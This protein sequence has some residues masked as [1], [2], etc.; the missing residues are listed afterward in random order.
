MKWTLAALLHMSSLGASAQTAARYDVL[1]SEILADTDPSAGL[2]NSSF[3]ELRNRSTHAI[4]LKGWTL[5]IGKNSLRITTDQKLGPDSLLILCSTAAA[6]AYRNYGSVLPI[7]GFP[8]LPDKGGTIA[9]YSND[10]RTIHAVDYSVGDYHN[11][12]KSEGG[13]SLEMIDASRPCLARDNWTASTDPGGGTPGK[14]N[15]VEGRVDDED[16]PHALRTF[17]PDS[18]HLLVLF[19]KTLD[20]ESASIPYRYH[21][22]GGPPVLAARPQPP[23][24]RSVM[25]DLS[26]PLTREKTCEVTVAGVEDCSGNL[27]SPQASLR[28]GLPAD[29]NPGG[30]VINEVLFNPMPD[31]TDYVELLNT[32]GSVLDAGSLYIGNRG[33]QGQL[34]S[35]AA[36]SPDP[37]LLFPGDHY[38]VSGDPAAVARSYLVKHPELLSTAISMPSMPDAEGTVVITDRQGRVLDELHYAESW[39]FALISDPEGVSLERIDPDGATQDAKNWHSAAADIGHGTPTWLN[40]QSRVADSIGTMWDIGPAVFS[41]DMDGWDDFLTLNYRFPDPGW[42]CSLTI[43]DMGGRPVRWLCRNELCGREGYFRW[44]GLDEGRRQPGY[45]AYIVVADCFNLQGRRQVYR[46]KVAIAGRPR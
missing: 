1:I 9:L 37:F 33:R 11:D 32:G 7:T 30:L 5:E 46:K 10:H 18:L 31:G 41:P 14:R 25:L 42:T 22:V 6:A 38:V 21:L 24:F 26:G 19:D 39:H 34:Q 20:S 45:G 17:P 23:F 12:L 2:P 13:W 36:C 43:Y 40:S 44:D 15:S 16:P 8:A 35:P 29:P 28:A 4:S 3:I 27:L